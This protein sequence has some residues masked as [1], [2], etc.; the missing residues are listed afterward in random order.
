MARLSRLEF[1]YIGQHG[2]DERAMGH[3]SITAEQE[4]WTEHNAYTIQSSVLQGLKRALGLKD[5]RKAIRTKR[6]P[7]HKPQPMDNGSSHAQFVGVLDNPRKA[8]PR[9]RARK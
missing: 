5:V 6:T 1:C 3:D 9:A 4:R 7:T 8:Q 2:I